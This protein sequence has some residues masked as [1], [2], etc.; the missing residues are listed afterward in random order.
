MVTF[1]WVIFFLIL[2]LLFYFRIRMG[3]AYHGRLYCQVRGKASRPSGF[4]LSRSPKHC[5]HCQSM[6]R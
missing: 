2:G 4:K 6:L 3:R 5:P 1:A